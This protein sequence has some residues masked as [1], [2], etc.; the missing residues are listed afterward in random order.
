MTF[1][2]V[3]WLPAGALVIECESS[4]GPVRLWA[5]AAQAQYVVDVIRRAAPLI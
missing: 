1:R 5:H 4:E 3:W 2:E